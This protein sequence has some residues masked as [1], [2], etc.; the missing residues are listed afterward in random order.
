MPLKLSGLCHV[1]LDVYNNNIVKSLI[2]MFRFHVFYHLEM[3]LTAN[4]LF[5]IGI[6]HCP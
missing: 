6:L 1:N 3:A 5:P 2:L 4:A